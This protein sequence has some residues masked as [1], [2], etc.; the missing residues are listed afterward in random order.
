[1]QK[2]SF[3]YTE[4]VTA[5]STYSFLTDISKQTRHSKASVEL[6]SQKMVGPYLPE[7]IS[8]LGIPASCV[9]PGP[10]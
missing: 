4:K 2:G 9:L 5:N 6:H 3:N 7:H 10:S 1:M 8:L